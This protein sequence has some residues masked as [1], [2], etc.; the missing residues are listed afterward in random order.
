MATPVP[1]MAPEDG[2][3]GMCASVLSHIVAF[4]RVLYTRAN[5]CW[6]EASK[7]TDMNDA[8]SGW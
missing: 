4:A 7:P 8:S 2:R 1:M 5:E 6:K 3:A